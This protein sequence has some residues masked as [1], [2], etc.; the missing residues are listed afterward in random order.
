MRS[1]NLELEILQFEA[2][3]IVKMEVTPIHKNL[4]KEKLWSFVAK[5][6]TTKWE[7]WFPL[8]LLDN[9][10]EGLH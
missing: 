6:V 2:A 4:L 7:N 9:T 5:P 1:I 10:K 8:A 3:L